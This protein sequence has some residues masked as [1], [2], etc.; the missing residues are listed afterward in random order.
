M[1]NIN[2]YLD[3]IVISDEQVDNIIH[4]LLGI[5]WL[6]LIVLKILLIGI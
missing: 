6:E 2:K 1:N 5:I 3:N 4:Q